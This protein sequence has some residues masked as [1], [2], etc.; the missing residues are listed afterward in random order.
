M[1]IRLQ[2]LQKNPVF[3]EAMKELGFKKNARDEFYRFSGEAK[4]WIGF[5]RCHHGEPG[6][7]YYNGSFMWKYP[8]VSE[9]VDSIF[10]VTNEFV[11]DPVIGNH[12]GYAMPQNTF[13]EW[14]IARDSSEEY[15]T[16]LI[17]TIIDAIKKYALPIMDKYVCLSTFIDDVR[18][19]D[20][21]KCIYYDKRIVSF[22]EEHHLINPIEKELL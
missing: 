4:Q 2:K 20:V 17:D 8:A 3:K 9:I 7:T 1:E 14:R 12:I 15:L 11:I 5:G 22:V 6:V 13:V 21:P 19:M 16:Q 10:K 18:Y